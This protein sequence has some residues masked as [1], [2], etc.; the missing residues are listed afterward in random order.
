MSPYQPN[1]DALLPP[2]FAEATVGRALA[3][4]AL[5]VDSLCTVS[6]RDGGSFFARV[7]LSFFS[8]LAF[9]FAGLGLGFVVGFGEAFATSVFL[10]VGFASG[11]G[12]T[13]ALDAG[14]ALGFGGGVAVALGFGVVDG[15]SIS[16]FTVVTTGFSAARSSCSDSLV[17]VAAGGCFGAGDSCFSDSSAERS[18]APPNHTM[19]SGF[20]EALAA[21]LQ[22]TSPAISAT[23]ANAIRT[24]FRQKRP[25]GVPYLCER[26]PFAI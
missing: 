6:L 9:A 5:P 25:L 13:F 15:N 10:G 11:F 22:R 24:T 19:L 2:A 26:S 23:W 20:D 18:P 17:S 7:I 3:L 4:P 1:S 14:V 16:L 8:D 12:V 21:T